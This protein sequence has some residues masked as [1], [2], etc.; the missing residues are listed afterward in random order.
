[1]NYEANIMSAWHAITDA[2]LAEG[3]EWYRR[4]RAEGRPPE[5]RGR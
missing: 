3:M 5:W 1:M 2:D 4:A